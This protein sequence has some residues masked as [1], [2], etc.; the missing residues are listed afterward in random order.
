MCMSALK[1]RAARPAL[2][3]ASKMVCDIVSNGG[4]EQDVSSCRKS[5]HMSQ[6]AL[7]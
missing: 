7:N 1:L 5:S 4:E 3:I 6:M 2:S